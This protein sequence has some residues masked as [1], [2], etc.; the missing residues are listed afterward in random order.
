[1]FNKDRYANLFKLDKK[2]YENW[3]KGLKKSGYATSPSYANKLIQLIETYNLTYYDTKEVESSELII[4]NEYVIEQYNF[5]QY[6]SAQNEDTYDEIAEFL[7]V[8]PWELIKYNEYVFFLYI[9]RY[10]NWN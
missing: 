7:G 6:V 4:E 5:V 1:M 10:A 3:A 9:V 2:D 8:W